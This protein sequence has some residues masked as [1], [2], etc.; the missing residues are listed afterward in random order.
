MNFWNWKHRTQN[1]VITA[2]GHYTYRKLDVDI[3]NFQQ[4]LVADKKQLIMI[5]CRNDYD[6][7]VAYLASLRSHHAVM[8]VS[9]ELDAKLLIKMVNTYKPTWIYGDCL[10]SG[11]Q[12]IYPNLWRVKQTIDV[13]IHKD[14][15]LLISTSGTTG[16][17][18]FV[19]LSYRNIQSN[20]EAIS[21]YL[22][23]NDEERALVN[24]PFSYSYGLSIV[25][26]H[27]QAG[28]AIVLTNQSVMEQSLWTLMK[29]QRVTSFAGV[30][31]T[32]QMLR[33]VGFFHM[34][35][36]HLRYFT[37]A[38]GRLDEK[39]VKLFGEYAETNQKRFYVM[40]GQ[41]EASPRMSYIPFERVKEKA[42]TIGIPI[43][44]GSFSID[45]ETSELI[46][47]G[48]NVMLGYAESLEDLKKGDECQGVLYTGDT[49]TVDGDGFY[50]ITGRLKRFIKLF[51][52]RLNLDEVEK[53]LE[54]YIQVPVACTGGDE[55]LTVVVESE[56]VIAKVKKYLEEVYQ[57]H[58]SAFKIYVVESIPRM[59]NGKTNYVA[60]KGEF[61]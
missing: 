48:E 43:P 22:Q 13:D 25:N 46:Y 15:A 20:A 8:L 35:L 61:K 40:Y 49:A 6:V 30:P 45:D 29:E 52:L 10:L 53:H 38:G 59:A 3:E 32:Y 9:A 11:Y 21:A 23:I 44:G 51:G 60:I 33:R 27:L 54:R 5:L 58:K 17:H 57:L 14:L 12:Q 56:K 41:T 55:Q 42:G 34:E 37:Q 39:L 18:K 31:F 24:L 47:R 2:G 16:S 28:A 50:T 1:A 36:P 7:I 19:R 4:Q 26:S